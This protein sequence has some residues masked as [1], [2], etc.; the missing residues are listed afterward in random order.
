MHFRQSRRRNDDYRL[1]V[2][3]R[4]ENDCQAY[5]DGIQDRNS[6]RCARGHVELLGPITFLMKR[7]R[8]TLKLR[9][10]SCCPTSISTRAEFCFWDYSF[11]LPVLAAD[12]GALKDEIIEGKTGFAFRSGD[13]VDLA[14]TIESY[15][16]SDLFANLNSRREGIRDFALARHSWDVVG[17]MT[18]EV[19]ANLLQKAR[20][21]VLPNGAASEASVNMRNPS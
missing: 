6:G 7:P 13:P 3:G 5:W 8:S 21:T 11:G 20:S 17:Q 12:V 14:A 1:I 10:F 4:P 15:F 9:T 16:A 18:M 2:A 19:Y